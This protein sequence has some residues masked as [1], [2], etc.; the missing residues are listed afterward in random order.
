MTT[1]P[2][3]RTRAERV[4]GPNGTYVQGAP[5]QAFEEYT[6]RGGSRGGDQ[7]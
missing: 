7:Y 3:G 2:D 5:R 1:A 4:T 6:P